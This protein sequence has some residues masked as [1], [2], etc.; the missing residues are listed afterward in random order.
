MY[1]PGHYAETHVEPL[2]AL[3]H[4]HPL[5]TLVTTRAGEFVANHIPL[6]FDATQG[7]RGTL[8]GH[9]ARANPVWH[10]HDPTREAL[11]IFHG[12]AAYVSPSWYPSKERDPRVVPTWNYAAV[13][14]YGPLR[15]IDD[16]D[17]LRALVTRLTDAHEQDL[18][19]RW[20]ISDAPR[21]FVD[22]MLRAI[23]G[24]EIPIT[25]LEGKWKMSQ[26]HPVE[27]RRGAAAGLR[28][29]NTGADSSVASIVERLIAED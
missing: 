13:H 9:V 17:W 8:R 24:F 11:A 23:V 4:D 29:R 26:N 19:G 14:A 12:P 28:A 10:E 3:M 5:A 6:E 15:V 21:D 2:H 27:N 25:R 18:P 22:R 20:H 16:R 1:L 7:E